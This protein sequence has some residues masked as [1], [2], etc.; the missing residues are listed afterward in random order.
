[1]QQTYDSGFGFKRTRPVSGAAVVWLCASLGLLS[2]AS[3]A[4]LTFEA[5]QQ[6]WRQLFPSTL[7]PLLPPLITAPAAGSPFSIAEK[8]FLL[9]LPHIQ[10]APSGGTSLLRIRNYPPPIRQA[11]AACVKIITP[12]WHG[13]GIMISADGDVLTS[14][15]LVAGASAV[16][17]QMLDGRLLAT[18]NVASFSARHDL[19]LLHVGGGPFTFLPA[20]RETMTLPGD[21][22]SIVGHPG[23]LS[24]KLEPG[25]VIRLTAESGT[26][27]MHFS[28][29][30][31]Q[32]NSGGPIVDEAGRLCAITACAA[33]LEDGSKV[34]VGVSAKAIRAFLS[35]PRNPAVFAD[36]A[37]GE[38][39]R[40]TAELLQ[41][42][43]LLT[44]EWTRE[45]LIAMS[46]VTLA[47]AKQAANQREE[48]RVVLLNMERAA[49]VS[50]KL[51]LLR[52][53]MA[54]CFDPS[55]PDPSLITSG[56]ELT[57]ALNRLMEC[58]LLLGE[59]S[60][61]TP[62]EMHL[63]LGRFR[64]ARTQATFHFSRAVYGL[65]HASHAL[66][67]DQ[68]SPPSYL[69]LETL[70]NQ[71][72]PPGRYYETSRSEGRS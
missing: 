26:D 31:G 6:E 69:R 15:H 58:T 37:T 27:V 65:E 51:L 60:G 34:K 48:Q 47:P 35:S 12:Y 67:F 14:Y 36:L 4:N 1:M 43:C 45:W 39:N 9:G 23:G 52:T 41:S 33:T 68:E 59:A 2:P 70:R 46:Q 10:T 29:D 42:L 21:S 32:G 63:A 56:M 64:Q 61:Q 11:H 54:H 55:T 3:G 17:V 16:T 18:T 5:L 38:K 25:S 8:H 28:A 53:V 72:A 62:T 40:R 66:E 24:W 57:D 22:L 50:L 13:A 19:A 49:K 71:Y 44:E 30:I 7:K 20:N